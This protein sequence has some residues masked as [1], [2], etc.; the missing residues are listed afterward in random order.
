MEKA[1]TNDSEIPGQRFVCLSLLFRDYQKEQKRLHKLY[2]MEIAEEMRDL[3]KRQQEIIKEQQKQT[4]N[5]IATETVTE[6]DQNCTNDLAPTNDT[7]DLAPTNDTIELAPTNDTTKLVATNGQVGDGPQSLKEDYDSNFGSLK[8]RGVFATYEEAKAH[9]KELQ[10]IDPYF[11]IF[12]GEIG[13]WLPLDPNPSAVKDQI[14]YEKEL[15]EIV[16]AEKLHLAEVAAFEE[17]RKRDMYNNAIKT[18]EGLSA[19]KKK[20]KNKKKKKSKM[21]QEQLQELKEVEEKEKKVLD[22][23]QNKISSK[24]LELIEFNKKLEEIKELTK[25]TKK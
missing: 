16:G 24:E 1:L 15:N 13:K 10:K 21:T 9:A 22:E 5:N 11:N 7:N 2:E 20:K 6:S 3:E 8:I 18:G 14:Y 4:E 17:Q 25:K 19:P 23:I 12:I